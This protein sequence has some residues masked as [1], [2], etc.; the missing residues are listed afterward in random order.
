LERA[1]LALEKRELL[2]P[3]GGT[4]AEVHRQVGEYVS[5][6]APQVVTLVELDPL[7]ATFLLN[8]NQLQKLK[9]LKQVS[10]AFVEASD[11]AVGTIESIAP[12]TDAESGTTAVRIRI[13]NPK[14]QLRGGERCLL[15]LP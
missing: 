6:A 8:R 15:E 12:I 7:A 9:R 13:A 2:A 5:P 1:R 10:V 3:L 11:K 4:V 14:G